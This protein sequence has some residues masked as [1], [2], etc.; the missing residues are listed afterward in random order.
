MKKFFTSL[1]ILLVLPLTFV[2]AGCKPK[3]SGIR[4]FLDD[5]KTEFV[6][7][8][9]ITTNG[10][11]VEL[12]YTDGTSVDVADYKVD[13][14]GVDKTKAGEYTVV[15]EYQ[16][17]KQTYKVHYYEKGTIT[18]IDNNVFFEGQ[19][20]RSANPVLR[21]TSGKGDIMTVD[22]Y[23]VESFDNEEA[24][25]DKIAVLSYLGE[26]YEC[27]V[28]VVTKADYYT[29]L[30]GKIA[31]ANAQVFV[32]S[33]LYH[34]DD[35]TFFISSAHGDGAYAKT[36][37]SEYW[38]YLATVTEKSGG[39]VTSH[40]EMDYETAIRNTFNLANGLVTIPI[41]GLYPSVSGFVSGFRTEHLAEQD[42]NI[43]YTTSESILTAT[44]TS[45]DETTSLTFEI[46]L[47]TYTI[48]SL[49]YT[50]D[51][52]QVDLEINPTSFTIPTKPVEE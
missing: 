13:T 27:K 2:F 40:E 3:D 35:D 16:K 29:Y 30:M 46:N 33:V 52:T 4:I 23:S 6:V 11:I 25:D 5:V 26:E 37:E 10:L 45:A 22:G 36:G 48:Y 17:H 42:V 20:F 28:K 50:L 31:G 12:R 18:A 19:D 34:I 44:I 7:G 1:M 49:G 47:R 51:G 43:E 14:S 24:G 8:E 32:N 15:I 41:S 39:T 21:Y 9:D 38:I